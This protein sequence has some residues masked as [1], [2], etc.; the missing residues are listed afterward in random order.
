MMQLYEPK[1]KEEIEQVIT[2][3]QEYIKTT[4]HFDVLWSDKVGYMYLTV[5]VNRRT[6]ADSDSWVILNAEELFDKLAFEM[7]IDMLEEGGH[8]CDPREASKLERDAVEKHLKQYT[9]QLPKFENR[10]PLIFTKN[11]A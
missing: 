5:D 4:P 7:A 2:V 6:V 8:T 3:F 9:H 11:G 10:I 1:V